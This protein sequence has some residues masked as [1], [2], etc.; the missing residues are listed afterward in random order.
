MRD[1]HIA[2][3]A[4]GLFATLRMT[5]RCRDDSEPVEFT[6]VLLVTEAGNHLVYQVI[7]VEKLQFH[8]RIIHRVWEVIGEGVT[9]R[10]HG[11]VVVGP[12]PFAEEVGETVHQHFGSSFFAV[13]EEEVFAGFL[14][15]AVFTVSE[16]TCKAGL[17]AG[18]EHY[19]AL[20]P[21]LFQRV[22]KRRGKA[23]VPGHEFFLVLGAVDAGKVEDEVGL[24]APGV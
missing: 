14:A 6:A 7:D 20:V 22:Q 10:S 3:P 11:T 16:S 21:V 1:R 2:I 13:L 15:S 18:A 12:A 17:L 4:Y 8:G 23:E 5:G 19:G 9:E 24:P